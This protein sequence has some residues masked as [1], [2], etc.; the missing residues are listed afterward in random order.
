MRRLTQ[1]F[2]QLL[3][4][5]VISDE[6]Y[7]NVWFAHRCLFEPITEEE[8]IGMIK[9]DDQKYCS[10]MGIEFMSFYNTKELNLFFDKTIK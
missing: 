7:K 4:G 9:Y 2:R 10:G 5:S 1:D 6:D 8:I 3:E